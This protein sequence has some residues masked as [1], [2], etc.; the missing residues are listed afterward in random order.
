MRLKVCTCN[1]VKSLKIG[2]ISPMIKPQKLRLLALQNMQK[3][4]KMPPSFGSRRPI[5]SPS[6]SVN[7][8]DL[9]RG[10]FPNDQAAKIALARFAKH[11][12]KMQNAPVIWKQTANPFAILFGEPF[13]NAMK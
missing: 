8:S 13:T 4:C 12:E 3:K 6:Y 1:C 7:L 10:H 9:N 5:H 2:G 11:A